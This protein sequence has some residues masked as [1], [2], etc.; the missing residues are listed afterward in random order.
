MRKYTTLLAALFCLSTAVVAQHTNPR[1]E[2]IRRAYNELKHS[3]S[4]D[5]DA[6]RLQPLAD[7]GIEFE[8]IYAIDQ[9]RQTASPEVGI[10]DLIRIMR[11]NMTEASPVICHR[12]ENGLFPF[13]TL[14]IRMQAGDQKANVY[15]MTLCPEN[16]MM[17]NFADADGTNHVFVLTWRCTPMRLNGTG[18][19]GTPPVY[20]LQGKFAEIQ[21]RPVAERPLYTLE[22]PTKNTMRSIMD[23][24]DKRLSY[25][26][27]QSKVHYIR[28]QF[29]EGDESLRDALTLALH[30]LCQNYKGTLNR[31][32][33][34]ALSGDINA[35]SQRL[36]EGPERQF[37]LLNLATLTERMKSSKGGDNHQ[38]V[39]MS[40]LPQVAQAVLRQHFPTA[41]S[42]KLDKE[43]GNMVY[44]VRL[45]SGGRVE[46]DS[47]GNWLEINCR[48]DRVPVD[49]IPAPIV[50]EVAKRWPQVYVVQIERDRRGYEVDL[51]NGMEVEFNK[52]FKVRD[53]D[54]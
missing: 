51:S 48:R 32:Q 53:I 44:T 22:N 17:E 13:K 38:N 20:Y 46:F 12:S 2:I 1:V 14:R 24:A 7:T 39:D 11:E 49:L 27:L 31:E 42:I 19:E 34:S 25:D 4:G 5:T 28:E 40:Q 10:T 41:T 16:V 9:A 50:Q 15:N 43:D 54:R 6:F 36:P 35:I 21:G 3:T 45:A 26:M 18:T 47:E 33:Y 8:A 29:E 52:Q 37:V 30:N 23:E